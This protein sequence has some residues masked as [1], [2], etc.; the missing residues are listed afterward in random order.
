MMQLQDTFA[1][2][3]TIA[4]KMPPRNLYTYTKKLKPHHHQCPTSS[5]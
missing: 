1:M 3:T 4:I 2:L 5:P